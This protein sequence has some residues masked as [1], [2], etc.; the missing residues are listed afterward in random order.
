MKVLVADRL[1][2]AS[3]DEMRAL[4]AE[5][6]YR[7]E[8]APAELPAALPGVNVLI[9]R[10]TE[11]TTQAF[12]AGEALNLIIRAGAGVNTIDVNTASERGVYVA[13][14]PGKNAWAVAELTMT[15]IGCLDRRIPDAVQSLRAGRWEKGEYAKAVGLRGRSIGIV[16]LGHIGRAVLKLAQCYGM[17]PYAYSR[18]LTSARA[19]EL[20]VSRVG[21][22]QELARLSQIFTIHLELTDR[23][24]QIIGYDVIDALPEG[25]WFVNTA[26]SE[27]VDYEAL[28]E[29]G[30][31]KKLR[32]GLDV[33]PDEPGSRF[34]E[35]RHRLLENP[36]VYAAPHIGASTDEAQ[37]AIAA[38]TVR[39][40]RSFLLKGEVPNAVN[41]MGSSR[42]RYQ[43]VV[44]HLDKVG[45]LANVLGVLKRH[46][47]NVQE[48][49]NAVF[50]G[51]KAACAKIRLQTRP[52]D[53]CLRE[54]MA[55]SEEILHVDLVTLPNLA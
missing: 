43:L 32:I 12:E 4:G 1:P 30:P 35:Y 54:I 29:L 8:L 19:T 52:S 23:T 39:I 28:L 18:S 33:L 41:L 55:F 53:A 5:V 27:L 49:D 25:A 20:G 3:L 17:V 21:S 6:V 37:T 50:E 38:E 9:V 31:N 14:C 7:P 48:L 40:L 51:G 36:L 26:R 45:A 16:G 46:G 22:I 13:N 44:R 11:V 47:I 24:R 15:L 34:S 42:A 2:G 10:G